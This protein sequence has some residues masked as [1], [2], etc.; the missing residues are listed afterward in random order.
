MHCVLKRNMC[1]DKTIRKKPT[2]ASTFEKHYNI[3]RAYTA[4][5]TF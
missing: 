3:V 2:T 5:I 1:I 4:H